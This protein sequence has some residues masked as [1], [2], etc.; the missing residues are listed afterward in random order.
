MVTGWL[1]GLELVRPDLVATPGLL[2]GRLLPI[3]THL[4][5][6]GF[7]GH[8]LFL[9][10]APRDPD[11]TARR[12]HQLGLV[13]WNL[14]ILAAVAALAAG[15]GYAKEYA[16]APLHADVLFGAGGGLVLGGAVLTLARARLP[17][18]GRPLALWILAPLALGLP[19]L[20]VL[21]NPPYTGSFDRILQPYQGQN[22]LGYCLGGY[23]A[24]A[25]FLAAHRGPLG[26]RRPSTRSLST[27]AV[28][29][30]LFLVLGLVPHQAGVL[31]R[32]LQ[33]LAI[34]VSL[35]TL[36]PLLDAARPLFGSAPRP[37]T[38]SEACLRVA[39]GLYLLTA[40][41]GVAQFVAPLAT[42][43]RFS[44]WM[45]G[46]AHLAVAGSMGFLALAALADQDPD[47]ALPTYRGAARVSLWLAVL[48][49]VGMVLVLSAGGLALGGGWGLD[50]EGRALEL[51]GDTPLV[52][53]RTTWWAR[54]ACAM[55]LTLG[56]LGLAH[57]ALHSPHRL[58]VPLARPAPRW[59]E[60]P[61]WAPLASAG[62]LAVLG[63]GLATLG[64][65]L[66]E[67][68]VE[69]PA[70]VTRGRRLYVREGCVACHT[71]RIRDLPV[72]VGFGPP[73]TAG[74][75]PP[76]AEPLFGTRRIGPD[77][78]RVG[79]RSNPARLRAHL[80]EPRT[81]VPASPMPA[82]AHLDEAELGDLLA[83]LTSTAFPTD[84]TAHAP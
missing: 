82:Y 33:V 66:P 14:G 31:P 62:L 83:F 61:R 34:L 51:N 3:H 56:L 39:L 63:V 18:G 15:Q 25:A 35:L 69:E 74:D 12:L 8:G 16:E 30:G 48:G 49:L 20:M 32:A 23:L 84:R 59:M 64:A 45:V 29:V 81:E 17:G 54:L 47:G 1:L 21:S 36:W 11:A 38:L 67:V 19:A 40:L 50:L 55:P 44:D 42:W 13:L 53:L 10:L 79:A 58:S 2:F 5:F 60:A 65:A 9:V 24:V 22:I 76:G 43:V 73:S 80:R 52:A 78:L 28:A 57:Q 41:Q 27:M 7:L 68:P 6:Y 4:V 71:R 46:H 77:L 72:D 75:Y 37:R 26:P 70:A